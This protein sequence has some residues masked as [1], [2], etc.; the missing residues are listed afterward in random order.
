MISM[1]HDVKKKLLHHVRLAF[2]ET[3]SNGL[4]ISYMF[5]LQK[6]WAIA[7]STVQQLST[8]GLI[9]Q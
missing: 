9:K 1:H 6:V 5:S 7:A 8:L 3:G 2:N 4:T